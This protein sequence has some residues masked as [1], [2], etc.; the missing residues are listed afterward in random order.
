[1]D[2]DS[3]AQDLSNLLQSE[4]GC[5]YTDL[6]DGVLSSYGCPGVLNV[7]HINIR[8]F[9]RN[10]DSLILLLNDLKCKGI[11]VHVIGLCETFLS[12]KST[13]FSN[14]ENYQVIHKRRNDRV[15]GGV[16]LLVHDSVCIKKQ[17]DTAFLPEFESVAA[18]VG[19]SGNLFFIGEFYRP[20]NTCD[21][22]FSSALAEFL[23]LTKKYKTSV[24]CCDQNYDFL[25][26]SQH[27]PT[28][29]VLNT[30]M[31]SEH[32][33]YI[34]KPTRITHRSS[35]LI[36][37]IYI[38]AGPKFS[39]KSYIVVDAM[40]D[41]YPC[42]VSC[43]PKSSL[44]SVDIIME[45]HKFTDFA[46]RRVTESE[47]CRLVDK[48]QPKSSCG[49]NGVSNAMLKRL[50][51]VIKVPLCTI[52]N[53]S[54]TTGVFPELLK[55]AKVVP[56]HKGGE[57]CLC[58]NYRP[59]SL[60]PVISKVLEKIVYVRLVSHL[61][62]N[63]VFYSRQYGFRKK[64][65]TMDAV[66]NLVS[67]ILG[68]FEQNRMVLAVFIDLRKAFNTI[69]HSLIIRKLECL[70]VSDIA[71]TWFK[72]YLTGRSQCVSLG[73]SISAPTH[74]KVGVAQGSLLGVLLFN[75]V[76]NDLYRSLKYSTAIL[77]ADDTTLI[78]SGTNLH[79]MKMKLQADLNGLSIWLKLNRLKLNVSKTKCMLFEKNGLSPYVSLS[80]DCE[81][82]EFVSEFKFL[83][84][85]LDVSLSF[86]AHY[87]SLYAKLLKSS[88]IIAQLGT[89]LPISCL[90]TLYYA[91]FH[92]H[93]MYRLV[94]WF[95]LL[96]KA[97][98]MNLY[99]LQKQLVRSA[100]RVSFRT[101]CVPLFKNSG[102]LTLK[103]QV[104]V[105]LCKLVHR[106]VS[107]QISKPV[108]NYYQVKSSY[109]TR[110][111]NLIVIKHNLAIVNKSHL[112]K[113]VSHW[114]SLPSEVK[115]LTNTKSLSSAVKHSLIVKY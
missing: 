46:L 36:D 9:Q 84:I 103:D 4:N 76:I 88:Y 112:C 51:H 109:T 59:I 55:I 79:F 19:H 18:E 53:V 108:R 43:A 97:L 64:H 3:I 94:V 72:S 13:S 110:N 105:E 38:K 74:L 22:N 87:S 100:N 16:S 106:I 60:L 7:L 27:K 50:I 40:S 34:H 71:L 15:G 48:M 107:G 10:K 25:K 29:E 111:A 33:P 78:I 5:E 86:E 42:F 96:C 61:D 6:E 67:E 37:N 26:M 47:I 39:Y 30:I 14:L 11:I 63:D 93:L 66:V 44:P 20:P 82:I 57:K 99:L 28:A 81:E 49:I 92:S 83:G 101:H 31:E 32:L 95:P 54:L 98:Q 102:I 65:S 17:I 114:N 70:G 80:V 58:D 75:L 104:V 90:K 62:E 113:T 35:T 69:S 45:K 89:F 1:M 56:L 23:Q 85:T 91:Y 21:V 73:K 8:S 2:H 115:K 24:I 77:Y 52:F 12:P 41:H 68:S